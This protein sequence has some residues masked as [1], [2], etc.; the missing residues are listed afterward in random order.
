MVWACSKKL[1]IARFVFQVL[2]AVLP[3]IPLYLMKL[4][5]DAFV[6]DIKP[7]FNYVL[8]ILLGFAVVKIITIVVN[9]AMN[10]VAIL[11]SEVVSDYMATI[12][13]N[14]TIN[15]DVEY[16]DSDAY[17]DIFSRAIAQSGGRPVITLMAVTNFLQCSISLLAIGALLLTLH[18]AVSL[19][20]IFI[21]IPVA[22]IHWYYTNKTVQ[23]K[24]EQTQNQR[25]ANYFHLVLSSVEYLKEVRIFNYGKTL[26]QRF[27]NL[28]SELREA[29]RKLYRN[30]NITIGVVQ[31]FE[32]VAIISALGFIAMQ[33]VKGNIS[34]GTKL[35]FNINYPSYIQFK[36]G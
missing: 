28:R 34:V 26:L 25:K 11:Q 19:I 32:A 14:K 2:I 17:H 30:Q 7:E 10:Y 1:T 23:L 9:N 36:N 12:V 27:L 13:L 16:F 18:W 20:L 33:A 35:H 22:L 31:G 6:A 4:L 5:L 15:T 3:L 29:R 21:A 24:E 8:M